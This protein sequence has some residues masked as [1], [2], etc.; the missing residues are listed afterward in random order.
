MIFLVNTIFF[1]ISF[2]SIKKLK[3]NFKNGTGIFLIILFLE[4]IFI[5]S[6]NYKFYSCLIL[7]S[8]IYFIDDIHKLSAIIRILIQL[9][10]GCLFYFQLNDNNLIIFFICIGISVLLVNTTNF[11]DGLNLNIGSYIFQFIVIIFI[12]NY[13]D[14]FKIDY[15]IFINLLIFMVL[16]LPFNIKYNFYFGDSGCFIFTSIVLI[17]FS[18]NNFYSNILVFL[19]IFLFPIVDTCY[20][21]LIR[22]KKKENLLTRNFYHL[23]HKIYEKK[24]NYY[25]LIPPIINNVVLCL[26]IIIFEVDIYLKIILVTTFTFLFYS[27]TRFFIN[28]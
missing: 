21:T 22:I 14:I 23:Y 24:N 4:L 17:F 28:K 3:S 13:F 25:Y 7:L 9:L 27:F 16:F 11:Q 15:F 5:N 20:V 2:L 6:N 19:N 18:I 1:L 12:F 10:L 26:L 8:L